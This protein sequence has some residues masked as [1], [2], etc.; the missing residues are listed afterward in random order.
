MTRALPRRQPLIHRLQTKR[1][2]V[3]RFI[4]DFRVPSHNNATEGDI[5]TV[6]LQLK[7]GGCFRTEEWAEAFCRIRSYLS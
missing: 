7:I 6:K 4:T 3:L 5:W 1:D 2:L